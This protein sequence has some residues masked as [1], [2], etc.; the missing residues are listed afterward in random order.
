MT[1]AEIIEKSSSALI[2]QGCKALK[3]ESV[4]NCRYRG[5]NGTKCAIG[6]L[7]PDDKYLPEMEDST[8]ASILE[9]YDLSFLLPTDLPSD[10]GIKFLTELQSIHDET[11]NTVESWPSKFQKLAEK[12]SR[13]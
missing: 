7:I 12:W 10:L 1:V 6:W 9:G 11:W 3:P 4:N 5:P 2:A 8:V 13:C